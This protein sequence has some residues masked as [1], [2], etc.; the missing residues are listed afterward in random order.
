MYVNISHAWFLNYGLYGNAPVLALRA[1]LTQ[2][3]VA[4]IVGVMSS[5]ASASSMDDEYL[6]KI[7]YLDGLMQVHNVKHSVRRRVQVRADIIGHARINM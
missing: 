7:D 6:H 5:E 3:A 4:D 2:Y 1:N